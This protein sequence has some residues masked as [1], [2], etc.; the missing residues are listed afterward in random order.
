MTLSTIK[1]GIKRTLL[2]GAIAYP[3]LF[4]TDILSNFALERIDSQEELEE[5]VYEEATNLGMNT[6]IIKC[7]LEDEIEGWSAYG[8]G[9]ENQYIFL[10]GFLANR[11]MVRHELYHLYDKHCDH[12]TKLKE[13]LNYWFV[14]E[15]K[16]IIYSF[17]G[18]K[19]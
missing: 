19:L 13:E 18:L 12:D 4:A 7:E 2:A 16:A 3:T 15:P 14:E 8:G 5:I 11:K 10:G 6:D 9:L 1:K 17:T